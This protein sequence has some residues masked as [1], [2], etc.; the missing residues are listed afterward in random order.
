M[1]LFEDQIAA[2]GRKLKSWISHPSFFSE[3]DHIHQGNSRPLTTHCP[4]EAPLRHRW[5]WYQPAAWAA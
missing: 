1:D 4:S 5:V 3:N 2:G